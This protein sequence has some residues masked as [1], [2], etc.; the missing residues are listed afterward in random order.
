[1]FKLCKTDGI[2]VKSTRDLKSHKRAGV[3][4]VKKSP[5]NAGDMSLVIE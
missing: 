1:M 3:S 4:V 2:F 5:A